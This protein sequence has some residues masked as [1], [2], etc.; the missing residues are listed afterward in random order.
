MF[1]NIPHIS[2]LMTKP[3]TWHVRQVK[4]QISLGYDE[5]GP[6]PRLIWV[7][8]VRTAHFFVLPWGGSYQY[9]LQLLGAAP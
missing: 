7:F 3:T 4:I 5:T 9:L 8:A 6:M 2:R 1:L